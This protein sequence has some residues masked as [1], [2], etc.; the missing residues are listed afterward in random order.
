MIAMVKLDE[1][2]GKT[3]EIKPRTVS[4]GEVCNLIVGEA[5]QQASHAKNN[6]AIRCWLDNIAKNEIDHK[7]A[8]LKKNGARENARAANQYSRKSQ[9]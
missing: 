2:E 6:D 1:C 5:K 9:K 8:Q 3:R 4:S 7:N